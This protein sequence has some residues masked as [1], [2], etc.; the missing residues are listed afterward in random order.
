MIFTPVNNYVY[1]EIV[2]EKKNEVAILLPHDYQPSEEPFVVVRVVKQSE[3]STGIWMEG[4][5]LVVEARMLQR[6][7]YSGSSFTVIKENYIIGLLD[8]E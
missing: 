7:Q 5:C 8:L 1:V 6:I 3:T 2:E 4:A